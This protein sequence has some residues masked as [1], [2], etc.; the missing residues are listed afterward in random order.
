MG[1]S[2]PIINMDKPQESD[3]PV[4][5]FIRLTSD[6]KDENKRSWAR[7]CITSLVEERKIPPSFREGL[8]SFIC[9]LDESQL[10]EFNEGEIK[11]SIPALL[12]LKDFLSTLPKINLEGK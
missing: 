4:I 10:L 6:E 5:G 9:G 8:I 2:S 3:I 11:V 12:Y 7:Q 1:S